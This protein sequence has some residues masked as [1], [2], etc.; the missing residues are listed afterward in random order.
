MLNILWI[1]GSLFITAFLSATILPI[2]SDPALVAALS[3]TTQPWWALIAV[4]TIGNTLGSMVNWAMGLGIERY[5]EK[6]W[7]P[8]KPEQLDRAKTTYARWGR[9]CLLFAWLPFVGDAF[10]VV[11]GVM[12][13]RL[14]IFIAL[15]GAGKLARYVLL[16]LGVAGF[17]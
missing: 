15:V 5:R 13:E 6:S 3:L 11:A 2:G 9:W 7:F 16:S 17:M 14:W 1:Y 8:V 4:A 12:K 10:T